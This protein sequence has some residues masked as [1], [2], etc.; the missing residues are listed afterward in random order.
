MGQRIFTVKDEYD[1]SG[2]HYILWKG[3]DQNG[4]IVANGIYFLRI[5]AKAMN[6]RNFMTRK[7]ILTR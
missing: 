1:Q 4:D 3:L 6:G 7:K 5:E 2:Y